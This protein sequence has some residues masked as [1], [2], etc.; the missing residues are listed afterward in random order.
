MAFMPACVKPHGVDRDI[1]KSQR[2]TGCECPDG[3]GDSCRKPPTVGRSS[4]ALPTS[5]TDGAQSIL[6]YRFDWSVQ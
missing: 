5:E 2:E 6:R 1:D 4:L 3:G